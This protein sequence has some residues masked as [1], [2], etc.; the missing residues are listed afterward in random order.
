[1]RPG[2]A[3]PAD[4]PRPRGHDHF[5]PLDGQFDDNVVLQIK[6]GP[7]DFQVREPVSP[8]IGGLRQTSLAVEF[9]IAQGPL[10]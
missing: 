1:L 3:G 9:Q 5:L 10:P 6:N 4:R 7:V 2:L 8:L